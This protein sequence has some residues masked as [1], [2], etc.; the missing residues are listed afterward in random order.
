MVNFQ[1]SKVK[2]SCPGKPSAEKIVLHNEFAFLERFKDIPA[3]GILFGLISG[4]FF[5]TGTLIV[6]LL[7][8]MYPLLIYSV[9]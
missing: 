3:I 9:R 6:K 5:A 8:P 2:P 7:H 4:V 1:E